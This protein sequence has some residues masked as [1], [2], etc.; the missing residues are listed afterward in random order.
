MTKKSSKSRQIFIC[1]CC[2]YETSKASDY[3]KH[4]LT[5]KHKKMTND[6]KKVAILFEC[7]CGKQL[8]SRQSLSRHKKICNSNINT[9][10]AEQDEPTINNKKHTIDQDMVIELLKQ[11]QELMLSNKEFK[12]LIV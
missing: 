2:D 1:E 9:I 5:R 12:E 11:N 3:N 4:I 8:S 10:N 6:D 7:E